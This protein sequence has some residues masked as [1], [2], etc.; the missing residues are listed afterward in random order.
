MYGHSPTAPTSFARSGVLVTR[1]VRRKAAAATTSKVMVG[2]CS[3][4]EIGDEKTDQR[5]ELGA[6][7]AY[8]ALRAVF[9]PA[10]LVDEPC[11]LLD[12]EVDREPRAARIGDAY[13]HEPGAR[14]HPHARVV[15]HRGEPVEADI[16][17]ARIEGERPD[18]DFAPE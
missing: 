4:R 10:V 16:D 15:D 2:L 17:H 12:V 5:F 18:A 11:H 8:P 14:I 13:A 9:R 6:S 7:G 3:L 1:C